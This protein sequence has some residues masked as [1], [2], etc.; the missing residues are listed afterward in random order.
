MSDFLSKRSSSIWIINGYDE[1]DRE[2]DLSERLRCLPVTLSGKAVWRCHS[3]VVC[4]ELRLGTAPKRE[5]I[6]EE[7]R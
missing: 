1:P 3:A 5:A 7:T 2:R 6:G 4:C